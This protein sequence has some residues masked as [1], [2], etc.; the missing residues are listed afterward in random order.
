MA[1]KFVTYYVLH[2]LKDNFVKTVRWQSIIGE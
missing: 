1:L 2:E